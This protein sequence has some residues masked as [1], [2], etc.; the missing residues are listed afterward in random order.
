MAASF[1]FPQNIGRIE[2]SPRSDEDQAPPKAATSG[3]KAHSRGQQ[4][5]I[6]YHGT[7]SCTFL[8]KNPELLPE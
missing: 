5:E 2:A 4:A 3:T 6:S 1:L 8:T 7:A